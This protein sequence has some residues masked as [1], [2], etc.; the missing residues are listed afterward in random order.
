MQTNF[1][2]E[3]LQDPRIAEADS[4]LQKC[5]HCGLCTAT[6]ST[7][8]LLGDERDSPRGRIYLMKDMFENA[9]SASKE[10]RTH[11]DRCLSCLSCMSTCP[12]GVDYMHLVDLAR[13]HIEETSE[14]PARDQMMRNMLASVLPFP[15][16]FRMALWAAMLARPFRGLFR[17]LHLTE[18]AAMLELAPG[19]PPVRGRYAGGGVARPHAH[20]AKRVAMLPGCAQQVLRPQINDATV[21]LF[22][23]Q[24]IEVIVSRE[25]GCCGALTHHMGRKEETELAVKKNIDAWYELMREEPLDAIIINASGC[26][27]TVKD[28]GHMLSDDPQYSRRAEEISAI[29]KDVTEFLFDYE[30]DAPQNWSSIK[31]A[32]HSACSMQ[33]G[34]RVTEEPKALLRKAGFTVMDIPEGHICCG[35]AGVYNILQPEIASQLRDRKVQNIESIKPDII[36]TGNIGCITQIATGTKIPIVH[37][38]ELLDWALGGPIPKGL[39]SMAKNSK[40][41]RSLYKE[42]ELEKDQTE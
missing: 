21:R 32:Y 34:Q 9:S 33:H 13:E 41:V 10:V 16:R 4:I 24:G 27:T 2:E 3:Q 12:S 11:V 5:V 7:Y 30:Q 38:V 40:N 37:T 35:S 20:R 15:S 22:A 8:V 6:C 25:S 31:V 17:K 18:L 28:Y 39:E 26:G 19:R 23:R 29:T 14:R 36:A 42:Q 1:S